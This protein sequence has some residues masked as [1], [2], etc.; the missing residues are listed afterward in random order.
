MENSQEPQRAVLFS[1]TDDEA[2][3]SLE[4]LKLLCEAAGIEAVAVMTQ[5]R[6]SVVA[7]TYFGKGKVEELG[8]LIHGM[9]ADVAVCDDELSGTQLRNLEDRL[10]SKVI[11]RTMLIL[12]I[13]ASRAISKEG[14]LQVEL[15]QLTYRMPRL[16]GFGKSLS[17]LGGGIGTRGP[18]EKK[19]E[20]DRRHIRRRIIDIKQALKEA[21]ENRQVQSS[22]RSKSELPKVALVGYTNAG[23]S[24]M[25]NQIMRISD[26]AGMPVIEENKL[27]ATLDAYSRRIDL[28]D[29]KVFLLVDTVG[30]VSKLPHALINA[31]RATLDEAKNA[32]LLIHVIDASFEGYRFQIETVEKTLEEIGAS[33]NERIDV[34]N[35]I[36]I[37]GRPESWPA[38]EA[39]AVSALTGENIGLLLDE[40]S[41]RI[42]AGEIEARVLIPY[43]RGDIVSKLNE[44]T[45]VIN[46]EYLPEGTLI[47]TKIKIADFNKYREYLHDSIG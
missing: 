44:E 42:F 5:K 18:G 22:Q 41:R 7:A 23:K 13:F 35:K 40:V 31:F 17:R 34:Y 27:F 3:R 9:E 26:S 38:S 43:S 15:A 16:S 32:D 10:D 37:A 8:D 14:K 45:A 2:G 46:Q 4:E 36:D 33:A 20:S 29:G 1:I 12:D 24:A 11:D 30:F 21:D 39:L 19:L 28:G 25:A 47:T 6:S